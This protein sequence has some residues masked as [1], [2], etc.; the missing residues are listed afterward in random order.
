MMAVDGRRFVW[1]WFGVGLL[2]C[3]SHD[4]P[5]FPSS[6]RLPPTLP[7]GGDAGFAPYDARCGDGYVDPGEECDPMGTLVTCGE[8]CR[9]PCGLDGS[10]ILVPNTISYGFESVGA[11]FFGDGTAVVVA[12]E[13]VL[14]RPNDDASGPHATIVRAYDRQGIQSYAFELDLGEDVP[15]DLALGAEGDIHLGVVGLRE[16]LRSYTLRVDSSGTL[17]ETRDWMPEFQI[18][19]I[20]RTFDDLLIST[21]MV[22]RED[23]PDDETEVFVEAFDLETG[24]SRWTKRWGTA[25]R[26]SFPEKMV[27]GPDAIYVLAREYDLMTNSSRT[28]ILEFAIEERAEPATVIFELDAREGFVVDFSVDVE[29]RPILIVNRS[30][31]GM[32]VA[33]E[34]RTP[35]GE[36][37]W[38]RRADE[39]LAELTPQQRESLAYAAPTHVR[40][41]PQG[42]VVAGGI[43]F[44]AEQ[45]GL[46]F[47]H[48]DPAG[49]PVCKNIH[50][51]PSDESLRGIQ[52]DDLTTGP[53]GR[54]LFLG[55]LP[56]EIFMSS[57]WLGWLRAP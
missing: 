13:T 46:W 51:L 19:F 27:A 8:D 47:A 10:V 30:D 18:F 4:D 54:S 45:A 7:P 35:E 1:L 37:L 11:E 3:Q 24:S 6:D 38:R 5:S 21:G 25:G 28:V 48:L 16:D 29:G 33:I 55:A 15:F 53:D 57:L 2:A 31:S 12:H 42:I 14:N 23:E 17:L 32:P 40:A 50:F 39:L 52:L 49:N 22:E 26:G 36:E 41:T 44:G 56:T 9:I 43:A 34:Q 20:D